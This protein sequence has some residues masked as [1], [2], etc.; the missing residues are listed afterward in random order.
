MLEQHE[1]VTKQITFDVDAP[2]NN[3]LNEF[4]EFWDI[5]TSEINPYTEQKYINLA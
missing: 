2:I 4:E 1:D 3:V 5:A